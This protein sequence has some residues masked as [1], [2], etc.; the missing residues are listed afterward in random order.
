MASAPKIIS[1]RKFNRAAV[2]IV[3]KLVASGYEAYIVGG[4][5]RDILLGH[6]PKDFDITT[7]ATPE[8]LTLGVILPCCTNCVA[9]CGSE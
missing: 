5:V 9:T 2:E 3:K 7:S 6:Q 1:P 8:P 4:A